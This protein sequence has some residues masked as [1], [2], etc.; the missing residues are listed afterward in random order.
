MSKD[1]PALKVRS[2]RRQTSGSCGRQEPPQRKRR[3][4]RGL[5]TSTNPNQAKTT[6]DKFEIKVKKRKTHPLLWGD[7]EDDPLLAL[8]TAEGGG[9]NIGGG[10]VGLRL[11]GGAGAGSTSESVFRPRCQNM[12][13][14]L[15]FGFNELDE[16][17]TACCT[18]GCDT[19]GKGLGCLEFSWREVF[20]F[21]KNSA[22]PDLVFIR[23]PGVPT[24][25]KRRN[26]RDA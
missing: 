26:N 6:Q 25:F 24:M 7:D 2:I 22:M 3:R 13:M 1:Q 5:A 20:A 12:G 18:R 9:G 21:P 19:L 10:R 4:S 14:L 23:V 15:F 11:G 17:S 16:D 8:G